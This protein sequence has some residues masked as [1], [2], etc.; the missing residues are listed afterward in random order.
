MRG[1]SP[2]DQAV[3]G[4]GAGQE[5]SDRCQTDSIVCVQK[6]GAPQILAASAPG[7]TKTQGSAGDTGT[8]SKSQSSTTN[9]TRRKSGIYWRIHPFSNGKVL[10]K[11][12]TWAEP[13][14]R[15]DWKR[16]W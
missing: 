13:G 10:S 14:H 9:T 11:D 15:K 2:S 8:A 6:P 5:W 16:N 3:S 1:T 12:V 4:Y 7:C